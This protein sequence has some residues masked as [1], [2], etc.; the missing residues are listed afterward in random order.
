MLL[1]I[2][3]NEKTNELI[4][5]RAGS[6]VHAFIHAVFQQMPT[7][8]PCSVMFQVLCSEG[9]AVPTFIGLE[10]SD[11]ILLKMLRA[12]YSMFKGLLTFYHESILQ[13]IHCLHTLTLWVYLLKKSMCVCVCVWLCQGVY[14]ILLYLFY[15]AKKYIGQVIFNT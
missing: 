15:M 9:N 14:V 12:L 3:P 6:V 13:S 10:F 1:A 11:G 2:W 8:C 5:T 7:I 4:L